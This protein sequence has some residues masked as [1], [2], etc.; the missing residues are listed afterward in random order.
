M[1]AKTCL[2][3][4]HSKLGAK[5]VDFAGWQMP[6]HYGS[7]LEEHHAVRKDAG[8]FDV[9]HM[10]VTD[11]TG[12]DAQIFLRRVLA[13]DVAKLISGKALYSCMLNPSGGVIDDLIVY[14]VSDDFY[15]IVSNAGTREKDLV[16]LRT[17]R[18]NFM[19]EITE[20]KDL[21]IIA[22]QGPNA[23]AKVNSILGAKASGLETVKPFHFILLD[24]WL[25]AR[26][27][28]TGEDGYEIILPVA[29]AVKF[30]QALVA[31]NIQ[32]CG[33]GARDTLRLEAGLNLYGAD[34]DEN[35][36]PLESNLAWTV[37]I[38][39]K[40]RNFIGRQALERQ[41]QQGIEKKLVGLVLRT[42]GILRSHQKI[43]SFTDEVGEILSGSFSPTLGVSIAMARVPNTIEQSYFVEIR[44]KQLPVE[45]VKLPFVRNGKILI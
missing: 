23:R 19:V 13:N 22:V 16:W 14:R 30:W 6:L 18:E 43:K 26:T 42:G 8:V 17:Q 12:T 9:S 7:Q 38:D 5:I 35:T 20:R 39:P 21:A 36:S 15:R 45:V 10:A 27:G 25:I 32:P 11:I 33:L 29:D 41:M 28:Y 40:D 24:D 37:A 44:G 3:D 4:E 2:Y 31:A 1:N 34:M